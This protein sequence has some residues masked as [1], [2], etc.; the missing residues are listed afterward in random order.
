MQYYGNWSTNN[1]NTYNGHAW[2][3]SNYKALRKSLRGACNGN[4]TGYNDIGRWSICDKD[5][6]L[7]YSGTCRW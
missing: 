1:G 7:L 2:E 3:S 4:L 5:G 6:N